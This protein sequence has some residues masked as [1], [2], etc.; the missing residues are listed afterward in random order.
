MPST[1]KSRKGCAHDGATT[2]VRTTAATGTDA[3][4]ASGSVSDAF[5]GV[6]TV[7][8]L[9]TTAPGLQSAAPGA[10]DSEEP[11]APGE[12][13]CDFRPDAF[14]IGGSSSAGMKIDSD[15]GEGLMDGF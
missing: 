15:S 9:V 13:E 14:A 11:A 3:D 8:E 5:C 2:T 4:D 1:K 6:T 7:P 10:A 12:A